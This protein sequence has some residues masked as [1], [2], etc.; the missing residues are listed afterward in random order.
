[1]WE[2]GGILSYLQYILG[3]FCPSQ[4]KRVG[5]ILS[6]GDFVLHSTWPIEAKFYVG[7]YRIG[8]PMCIL[9]I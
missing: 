6:W 2:E 1:M 7:I 9:I 3:G 5:G 8:E 4:Q